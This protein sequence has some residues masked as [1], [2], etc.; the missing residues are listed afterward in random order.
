MQNID[1]QKI[2]VYF[3]GYSLMKVEW[4]C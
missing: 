1:V 4:N 2:K 3:T